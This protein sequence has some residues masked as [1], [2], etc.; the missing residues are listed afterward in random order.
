[1]VIRASLVTVF[2]VDVELSTLGDHH[3]N[4]CIISLEM[5][6]RLQQFL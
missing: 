3:A 1:M 4:T 5:Q 2:L 6:L